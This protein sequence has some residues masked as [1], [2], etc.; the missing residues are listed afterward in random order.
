M[1]GL[2]C[3]PGSSVCRIAAAPCSLAMAGA[4]ATW[5]RRSSTR[6]WLAL[7]SMAPWTREE[8]ASTLELLGRILTAVPRDAD[9]HPSPW[10]PRFDGATFGDEA[11]LTGQTFSKNASFIK[12]TFANGATFDGVTFEHGAKFA[13]ATFGDRAS[14]IHATLGSADF[15]GATFGDDAKFA[16]A[17]FEFAGFRGAIFGDRASFGQAVIGELKVEGSTFRGPLNSRMQGSVTRPDLPRRLSKREL[18]SLERPS[19]ATPTLTRRPSSGASASGTG[20]PGKCRW[21]RPSSATGPSSP[22][23]PSRG[24][25]TLMA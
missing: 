12:A 18:V 13:G 11:T 7:A 4:L 2:E 6:S 5:T 21:H 9:G 8:C 23:Q 16:W 25:P 3:R 14:F 19:V 17:S 10:E 20:Q 24:M 22:G 15:S 1:K